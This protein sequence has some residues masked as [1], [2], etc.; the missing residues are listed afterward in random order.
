MR[1]PSSSK[2]STNWP[3]SKVRPSVALV[4]QALAVEHLRPALA[5]EFR[6]LAEGNH[7]GD[8]A[9]H[10]FGD[11]RAARH[12]D[13]RL[14]GDDLVDR[15]GPRRVGPAACTQPQEAQEP[16]AMMALQ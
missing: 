16:Q 11:R 1:A 3:A 9:G 12:L 6:Q 13:D 4:V 14:V 10:D 15:R 5:V 8:D 7:V 2:R